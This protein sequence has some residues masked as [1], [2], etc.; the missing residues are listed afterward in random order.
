MA[1]YVIYTDSAC[2]VDPETLKK[3]GVSYS[4]LTFVFDNDGRQYRNYDMPNKAF[5]DNIRAGRLA[6]TSAVNNQVFEDGFRKILETG[7]DI[8][9]IGFSSGLSATFNNA[10]LAADSLREQFPERKMIMVDSRCASAGQGLLVY[11]TVK[12][13]DEGASLDEAAA[14]AEDM[15][16]RIN[17]WYTVDDL[18]YLR[19]GGRIG[20]VA[21]RVVTSIGIKPVM[22]MDDP[23]HLIFKYVARGRKNSLRALIKEYAKRVT[24]KTMEVFISHADVL[25]E[26]T[27]MVRTFRE[28][29]GVKVAYVANIGPV[30]GGH[31]G[32]GCVA[33]FFVG[34]GR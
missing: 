30:I 29:F 27:E 11:L 19:K 4:E 21:A 17:H 1:D 10:V 34:S 24:D 9:Y 16:L 22:N 31:T 18:K 15:K 20:A 33:L 2:D 13:R 26:V 5:Y 12:K 28:E 23:G 7:R 3:W 25:D 6:A 8:L 32:P 14:Y